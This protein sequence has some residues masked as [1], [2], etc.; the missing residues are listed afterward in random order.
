[1]VKYIRRGCAQLLF[2]LLQTEISTSYIKNIPKKSLY[3]FLEGLEGLL[4]SKISQFLISVPSRIHV[5][6]FRMCKRCLLITYFVNILY[7][8][9][10]FFFYW[11]SQPTCGF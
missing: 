9:F 3:K 4:R 7:I 1:M 10:F 11:L 8:F 5:C 6:I 2:N